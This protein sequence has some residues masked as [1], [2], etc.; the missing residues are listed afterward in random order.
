[1]KREI[2]QRKLPQGK[3]GM[4]LLHFLKSVFLAVVTPLGHVPM[5]GT[6]QGCHCQG[7]LRHL[8]KAGHR[9]VSLSPAGP[10]S[11]LTSQPRIFGDSYTHRES[12]K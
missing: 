6:R 1:M 12:K 4:S 7:E 3:G 2:Y 10:G 5:R 11:A 8:N 9:W